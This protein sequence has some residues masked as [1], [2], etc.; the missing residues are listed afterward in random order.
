MAASESSSRLAL[1]TNRWEPQIGRAGVIVQNASGPRVSL[2][3]CSFAVREVKGH[4][5]GPGRGHL[6]VDR[7]ERASRSRRSEARPPIPPSRDGSS[8]DFQSPH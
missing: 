4:A 7:V 3:N 5:G 1:S 2:V 6:E 8:S